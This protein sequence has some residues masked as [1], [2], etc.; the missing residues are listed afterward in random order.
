MSGATFEGI[1]VGDTLILATGN[2]YR[3][4]GPVTVSRIGSKYVYVA[5][6]GHEMRGRFH[7]KDGTED[8]QYG[9]RSRLYTPEQY[10]EQ[11]ERSELL[12]NLRKAGIDVKYEVRS[13]V[14]TDQLRALL[15][16][17]TA[18]E[19]RAGQTTDTTEK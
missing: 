12:E 7:R 1:K 18:D 14:T 19:I 15:T 10:R 8:T 9:A 2:R 6:N 13:N 3:S 11:A 4:D 5:E 16:V 17:I